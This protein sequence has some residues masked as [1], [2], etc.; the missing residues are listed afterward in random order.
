MPTTRRRS[1]PWSKELYLGRVRTLSLEGRDDAAQRWYD[2]EG[3]PESAIAQSAPDQCTTCGFLVRMSGPLS[4]SFGVC[5]N[6]DANDDGR[7]VAFG[8]GCGA[9]SEVRLAKRHEPQPVPGHVFDTV[10][11]DEIETF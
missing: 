4:E 5:A 9:H 1:A 11:L 7:V 3:G 6:G 2:G 8:H 10:S